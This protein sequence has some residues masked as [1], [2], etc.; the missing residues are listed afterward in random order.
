VEESIDVSGYEEKNGPTR[1][2]VV[3]DGDKA[4][5]PHGNL[6]LKGKTII[7]ERFSVE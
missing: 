2:I 5:F 6:Q 4:Q 3:F 7:L 1:I